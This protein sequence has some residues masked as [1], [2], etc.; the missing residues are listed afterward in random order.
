MTE[1]RLINGLSHR[2]TSEPSYAVMWADT[3]RDD[4]KEQGANRAEQSRAGPH[5]DR[6]GCDVLTAEMRR[7]EEALCNNNL[8]LSNEPFFSSFIL[9]LLTDTLHCRRSFFSAAVFF[10]GFFTLP[11]LTLE[12]DMTGIFH[13]DA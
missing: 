10:L 7:E 11:L 6:T 2:I 13:L 4:R 3:Q 9:L 1:Y 5:S 8:T 12:H